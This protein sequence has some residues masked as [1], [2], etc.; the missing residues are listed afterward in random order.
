MNNRERLETIINGGQPDRIPAGFRLDA[1]HTAV[2]N[3]GEAPEEIRGMSLPQVE[4]HLGLA[5]SARTGKVFETSLRAPVECADNRHGDTIVTE[6]RT[7][8]GTLQRVARWGPGDE[9]AGLKATT[10]EY[11]VIAG[12]KATTVEYPVKTRDDY[13][14]LE[15]VLLHTEYTPCLEAFDAYDREIGGDGLPMVIL[16]TVPFH[17]VLVTWTGYQAGYLHLFDHEDVFLHAVDVANRQRMRTWEMVADSNARLVMYGANFDTLTTPPP[18]FAEHIVPHVKPFIDEMHRRGKK[19]ACHMDAD[20]SGLLGLVVETGYDVADC[21][22][23][24]PMVRC[25]FAEARQAWKDQVTIWG[26]VPS[27]MLEARV[28]LEELEA[29]LRH[30]YTCAAPGDRFIPGFADQAMPTS[31]WAHIQCVADFAREH[32]RYPIGA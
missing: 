32:G 16:G 21:F 29:H 3:R 22:A 5:R 31:D 25:E 17:Q 15:Q 10:V 23:C 14:A 18:L 20:S 12:L 24:E 27:P 28:P 19:V 26:A 11:P 4:A 13:A 7:P 6:W 8:K 30:I 9:E 2:C 1:W